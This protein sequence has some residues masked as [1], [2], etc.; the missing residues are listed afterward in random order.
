MQSLYQGRPA[1][2][3]A[4]EGQVPITFMDS[5]EE[6]EYWYPFAYTVGT[7]Y[8]GSPSFSVS[9]FQELCK[10][11]IILHDVLDRMYSERKE[12]RSTE[13]LI[14]DLNTLETRMQQWKADLPDHLSIALNDK[15]GTQHLPPPHVFS[16]Q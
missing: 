5:Y 10:L 9:T 14:Q 3:A 6:L 16:L 8:P 2:L 7:S 13:D 11:C 15:D 1:S 12:R 4:P